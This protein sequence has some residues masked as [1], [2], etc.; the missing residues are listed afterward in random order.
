M[1]PANASTNP[2]DTIARRDVL[3]PTMIALVLQYTPSGRSGVLRIV[4]RDNEPSQ[5][6]GQDVPVAQSYKYVY[7]A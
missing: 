4:N 1:A 5:L 2:F 3:T 6:R 7:I